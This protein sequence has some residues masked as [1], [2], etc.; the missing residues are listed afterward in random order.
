M[1]GRPAM[2]VVSVVVPCLN[3]AANL[4]ELYRR[5][6]QTFLET[7]H[8][9]EFVFIDD[10]STDGTADVIETLA[11][12]DM[13]VLGLVLSRNFGHESAIAA[14]L[15]A[16]T[17]DAAIV[18]DADLQDAPEG[19]LKLI[20]A[21]EQGADVVY[22]VRTA[23]KE[24]LP[25][26]A[27]FSAYYWTAARVMQ[28][29]LPRNAGPFSL[30]SRRALEALKAMPETG[31]YFPGLRAFIG[32]DQ[33]PVVLER[34]TRFDGDTKYSIGRRTRLAVDAILA[35]ST[36]PL[37]VVA[38]MGLLTSLLAVALG[39]AIL[40]IKLSGDAAVPG[41]TSI[42]TVILLFAGL[43]MFTLGLIG[44]YVGRIYE[45]VKR[46]PTYLLKHQIG[47]SR[48][49]SAAEPSKPTAETLVP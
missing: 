30:L 6:K 45:E 8:S 14:G 19:I 46:R 41:W 37:T 26:R 24:S 7:N 34:S 3:E 42:I 31:R 11:A 38:A 27:A 15:E 33:R 23:R 2:S 32:F 35:F 44:Q 25:L 10:G 4:Q 28:I 16:C 48:S 39:A 49:S 21:W 17:G 20:G 29:D 18:M 12:Q 43:Q 5:V 40:I 9:P 1:T 13:R 47:T 22:A 36:T